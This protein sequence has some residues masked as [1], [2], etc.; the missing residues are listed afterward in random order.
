[1]KV[2]Y[3]WEMDLAEESLRQLAQWLYV[4]LLSRQQWLCIE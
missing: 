2:Q 1:M 4:Q 3:K